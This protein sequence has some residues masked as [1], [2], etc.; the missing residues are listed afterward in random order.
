MLREC[1]NVNRYSYILNF[2]WGKGAHIVLV[3]SFFLYSKIKSALRL[4]TVDLSK[5]YDYSKKWSEKNEN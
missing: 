1:K 5:W 3:V 2:E 4:M